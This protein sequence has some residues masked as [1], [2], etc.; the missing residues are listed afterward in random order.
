MSISDKIISQLGSIEGVKHFLRTDTGVEFRLPAK[1][2]KYGINWI[3]IDFDKSENLYLFTAKKIRGNT[4][5][6]MDM[7]NGIKENDIRGYFNRL[8]GL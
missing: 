8:T 6:L 3:E 5:T 2:A 1:V 4:V 7:H